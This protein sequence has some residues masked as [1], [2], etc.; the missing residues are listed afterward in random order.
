[1]VKSAVNGVT[2]F[3]AGR[4]YQVEVDGG[5]TTIRKYYAA[6][7]QTIAVRTKVNSDPSVVNWILGDH[8]GNPLQYR[9]PTNRTALHALWGGARRRWAGNGDGH[10]Y[11]HLEFRASRLSFVWVQ[12]GCG[13][14]GHYGRYQHNFC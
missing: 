7:G 9:N 13:N 10:L 4:H 12:V 11:F 6:G 5:D 1:M 3:F 2:T 14:K 8:L